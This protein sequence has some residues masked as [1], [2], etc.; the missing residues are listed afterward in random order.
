MKGEED[1]VEKIVDKRYN[2]KKVKYEYLVKWVGY[3]TA[4]NTW[5]PKLPFNIVPKYTYRSK[6]KLTSKPDFI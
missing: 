3:T 1:E 6:G 2:S 4:Q 5:A